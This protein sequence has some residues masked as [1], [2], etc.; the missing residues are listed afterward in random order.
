VRFE[1]WQG[2][3]LTALI[4]GN[5]L[6]LSLLLISNSFTHQVHSSSNIF[7]NKITS[8]FA[9]ICMFWGLSIFIFVFGVSNSIYYAL[10][11]AIVYCYTL[12]IWPVFSI[13]MKPYY[14]VIHKSI[15][16]KTL[17]LLLVLW[18]DSNQTLN[19]ISIIL[20]YIP[21]L[22]SVLYI[23]YTNK[24]LAVLT[25]RLGIKQKTSIV[26]CHL[27]LTSFYLSLTYLYESSL[28][29]PLISILLVIQG[30]N[31]LFHTL[32]AKYIWLMPMSV[33]FFVVATSKVLVWDLSG[34]SILQKV[35]AFMFI[36]CILLGSAFQFQKLKT[37]SA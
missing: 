34:L 28:A 15:W 30:T 7:K 33:G 8:L 2:H 37:K 1:N 11:C 3:G 27:S 13:R 18:L 19:L 4:L 20:I 10:L 5:F 35:I 21:L 24:P 26:M 23:S 17:L 12:V 25:R 31:L 29:S 14:G 22:I 9:P 36:G 16:L 32:K 6:L